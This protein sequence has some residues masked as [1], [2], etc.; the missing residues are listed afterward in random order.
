MTMQGD[1]LEL[2]PAMRLRTAARLP[3]ATG[4]GVLRVEVL[5]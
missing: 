2:E 3:V 1:I 4:L 5:L